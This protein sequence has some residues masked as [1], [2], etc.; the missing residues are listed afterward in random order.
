MNYQAGR[1]CG[2]CGCESPYTPTCD[3]CET[4]QRY[5]ERMEAAIA[6]A[7]AEGYAE[8]VSD[9]I[10]HV[11]AS[12]PSWKKLDDSASGPRVNFVLGLLVA[13]LESGAH[14]GASKER[15]E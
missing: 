6:T 11:H 2:L 12:H 13:D 3:G 1:R 15:V 9:V 7:R 5:E 4:A 8:A 10:T 14:V